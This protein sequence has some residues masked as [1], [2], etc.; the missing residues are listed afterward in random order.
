RGGC[1]EVRAQEEGQEKDCKDEYGGPPAPLAQGGKARREGRDH[2]ERAAAARGGRLALVFI[3]VGRFVFAV[4]ACGGGGLFLGGAVFG[5]LLLVGGSVI[6]ALVVLV[7]LV[8]GRV[9][10]RLVFGGRALEE[11]HSAHTSF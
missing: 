10:V 3:V 1:V 11:S 5:V 2:L 8:F 4:V 9:G 6:A 7:L